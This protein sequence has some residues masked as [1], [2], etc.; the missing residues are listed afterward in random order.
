M[1]ASIVRC[2]RAAPVA[3]RCAD[4]ATFFARFRP[5]AA[6]GGA[7][8]DLAIDLGFA[9]DRVAW[10]FA[11]GYQA[12]LRALVPDLAPD[13]IAS[14]C[15]TEQGGNRPRHVQ[16]TLT[17]DGAG[18]FVLDGHK[19]W[20]TLGPASTTL[21]VVARAGGSDD[22][23]LLRVARIDAHATG[24]TIE[25][26]PDTPFVPEVPHA[27]VRLDQVRVA[28]DALLDGDGYERC[29]KPFRTIEDAH[30]TAAIV[31]YLLAEARRRAWPVAFRDRAVATLASLRDA[32]ADDPSSPETHAALGGA[33]AFALALARDAD[34]LFGDAPGDAEAARFRRDAP[35][36]SVAAVARARRSERAWERLEA[37]LAESP[38]G[39][40]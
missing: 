17:G 35:L 21:L 1:H 8:I 16:T 39:A 3:E 20:T 13:A 40:R 31:A 28:A 5:A 6:R 14:L 32:G 29:V 26:Q 12:A 2:L 38:E 7:T 22:R 19:R 25:R 34:A 15:V 27:S 11:G 24:V 23:P 37:R 30:V 18:G 36:L 33:L 4:A 10:A 9:A